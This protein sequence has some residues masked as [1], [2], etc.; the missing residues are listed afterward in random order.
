MAELHRQLLNLSVL[1]RERACSCRF[2]GVRL[3]QSVSGAKQDER[4]EDEADAAQRFSA[5]VCHNVS[6]FISGKQIVEGF[7][8]GRMGVNSRAKCRCRDTVVDRRLYEVDHL[9]RLRA[10]EMRAEDD[11]GLCVDNCL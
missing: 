10:E 9:L 3:R 1:G 11:V 7:G 4:H 6:S 8:H 2:C 5:E